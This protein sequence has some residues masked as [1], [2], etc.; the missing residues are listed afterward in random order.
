MS[1]VY[2]LSWVKHIGCCV[3]DMYRKE[4]VSNVKDCIQVPVKAA[5]Y[6]VTIGLAIDMFLLKLW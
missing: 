2:D 6:S 3:L 1:N 4:G 5:K